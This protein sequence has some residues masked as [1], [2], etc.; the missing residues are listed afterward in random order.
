MKPPLRAIYLLRFAILTPLRLLLAICYRGPLFQARCDSVG[1]NL[2]VDSL[3]WV[4]GPVEVHI[5]NDVW[6]GGNM[7][8]MSG[9][10]LEHRPRLII[11][12]RA[13]I[14][15]GVLIS[16]SGE[17]IVEEHA[18]VSFNCCIFDNDG[19]RREADLRAQNVP[20]DPRDIRPVRICRHAW[21]GNGCQ[22]MKGVTIGEGAVIG[23]HSVVISDIPPYSLAMGNPAEVY[24]RNF[25]RPS[26]KGG[27]SGEQ[28]RATDDQAASRRV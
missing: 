21:I 6:L 9:R 13:E 16:V 19:H 10:T 18:R 26:N 17:V 11:K 20:V 2:S 1:K 25:G 22:I 4:S 5:G 14:G 24:F 27:G 15:W 28:E 8:I 7:S 23:A 3:P 12:D